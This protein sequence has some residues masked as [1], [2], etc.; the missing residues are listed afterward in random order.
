MPD[1]VLITGGTGFVAGHCINEL[2]QHGYLV[3]ATVRDLATADVAHL[4]ALAQ[5]AGGSIQLVEAR[6]EAD[7]GWA[8]VVKD[9]THVWHIASPVP[10]RAP[11][12]E[13]EVIRP[14]VGGTLRVLQAA[15]ASATVRRVVMT[16]S[17]DA[18]RFGRGLV[19]ERQ[20]TEADW[21]DLNHC[22]AYAK[23]KTYAEHAAWDFVER[24]DASERLELV[25]INPGLVLGPLL[26]AERA[27]SLEAIRLLM[28][29]GLPAVPRM[30]FAIVDV[31]DVARAHRLAMELPA[32]AGNRYICAGEH[33]WMN[34][35]ASTLVDEFGPRGYRI[36]TRLMPSWLVQTVA[37]FDPSMRRVVSLIDLRAS[38]SAEK[39]KRDL[40]WSTRPAPESIVDTAE[41]LLRYGI[42][43]RSRSDTYFDSHHAAPVAV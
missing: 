2:L 5:A 30:G 29:R 42:V 37:R 41:S 36:P 3:R 23:S 13:D 33:M 24:Q 35:I 43:A 16:S 27:P 20:Y 34:E 12:H 31:R 26:H 14:A 38:V 17:I 8:E 25:T 28:V 7:A 40:G 39:A 6:L 9:C 15:A 10:S 21:S 32:A 22:D 1:R 18:I 11:K 4:H 19:E